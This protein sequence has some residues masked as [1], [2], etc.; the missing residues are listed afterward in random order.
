MPGDPRLVVPLRLS[1]I[2]LLGREATAR[3]GWFQ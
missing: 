3:V 2:I 1:I